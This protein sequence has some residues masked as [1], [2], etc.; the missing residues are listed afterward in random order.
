MLSICP[1]LMSNFQCPMTKPFKL[2]AKAPKLQ[3]ANHLCSLLRI[4]AGVLS[5]LFY[6]KPFFLLNNP[7]HTPCF[8][9]FVL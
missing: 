4:A 7:R 9:E 3:K 6:R 5:R 2:G 1:G 8:I